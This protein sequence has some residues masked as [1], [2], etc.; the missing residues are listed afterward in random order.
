DFQLAPS[1]LLPS[2]QFVIGGAQSVRGY[3]QNVLA[4]DYGLRF[5]LEDRIILAR[6]DAND[7]VF[8]LAPFF[9]MG[10]IWNNSDNPNKL[11][12]D[13]NFIA[14]IGLGLIWEPLDGLNFRVDYAPPLVNLN[15]RGNNVQDDGFYFSA[16]YDF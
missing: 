13:N 9:D 4:G 6:N 2:E 3:R 1:P 5:S 16:T 10:V 11:L 7:P 14:G 12:A 15:I 8:T